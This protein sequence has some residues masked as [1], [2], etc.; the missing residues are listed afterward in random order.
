MFEQFNQL[1]ELNLVDCPT[2]L[3]LDLIDL[4]EA[5]S[6]CGFPPAKGI[7]F[8]KIAFWSF[9]VGWVQQQSCCPGSSKYMPRWQKLWFQ[10]K[11]SIQKYKRIWGQNVTF[12]ALGALPVNVFNTKEVSYW[13]PD[14][15]VPK[16][17][18]LP[19]KIGFLSDQK[20]M[21]TRCLCGF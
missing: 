15:R 13:F 9:L 1:L 17:S 14:M 8:V 4:I 11:I 7:P 20:T 18:S 3:A 10:N 19:Q 16:V 5:I 6:L 2:Q 12:L 21:R